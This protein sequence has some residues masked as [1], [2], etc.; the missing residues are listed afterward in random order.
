[1]PE[2]RRTDGEPAG[3]SRRPREPKPTG[4]GMVSLS[5][6]NLQMLQIVALRSQTV[7]GFRAKPKLLQTVHKLLQSVAEPKR[8]GADVI[9]FSRPGLAC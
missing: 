6:F 8:R 7:A 4:L 5:N 3:P 1:M 2:M 9:T